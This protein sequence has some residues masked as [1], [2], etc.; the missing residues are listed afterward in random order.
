MVMETRR[1]LAILVALSGCDG[2]VGPP[3]AAGD[4]PPI[5]RCEDPMAPP[6]VELVPV[7][8]TRQ[9]RRVTLSLAGRGPTDEEYAAVQAAGDEAAQRAEV[10]RV[11]DRLLAEPSF[12][13]RMVEFGHDW[14]PVQRLRVGMADESY[15]GSQAANLHPCDDGTLHPGALYPAG[16]DGGPGASLCNDPAPAISVEP[17]WAPGTTVEVVNLVGSDV[18]EAGGIDCGI[19]AGGYYDRALPADGCSCGPNLVYCIPHSGFALHTDGDEALPLRQAWDEPARLLAH[20][21][22]HDRPLTDFVVGNYTVAPLMLRH[23]YVRMG[24]QNSANAALDEDESWWRSTFAGDQDPH[25]AAA[26][27]PLAWREIVVEKL[28]PFLM[29]LSG[30][31]RSADLAR[32]YH[33]DPRITNEPIQGVAASGALTTLAVQSSF[34]RERVRAARLLETF[35]CHQFTPPP[36]EAHLG[37]VTLDI[38][39]EGECQ[40]CHRLMDP[41]A[42]HFKRWSFGLHYIQEVSYIPGTATYPY[43]S[44]RLDVQ[45]W[46]QLYIPGTVLTPATEEELAINPDARLL[47]FLPPERELFGLHSDG[48]NGPLGFAKLLVESGRFDECAVRRIYERFVGRPLDPSREAGY[49]QSLVQ[50]FVDGDR[51]VRPFVRYLVERPDFQHG[52]IRRTP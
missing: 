37:N 47:D 1:Y 6:P 38:A 32:T 14:V 44:E 28:D 10:L 19:S 52:A 36:P 8:P 16:D 35:A 4:P 20:I 23:L 17:W 15:W 40:Y 25:H 29:S 51:R 30:G 41:A 45:R 18:R 26:T 2:T 50:T 48:T 49:I 3:G 43:D 9:L 42:I 7:S 12:Y 27:D 33:H 24:R 34:P 31:E 39:L 11:A 5:T 22:W 13:D 21:A 46:E